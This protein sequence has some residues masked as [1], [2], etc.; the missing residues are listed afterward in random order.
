MKAP[1]ESSSL[2]HAEAC[3]GLLCGYEGDPCSGECFG[4]KLRTFA[5]FRIPVDTFVLELCRAV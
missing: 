3:C 4:T 2:T 5:F 1:L